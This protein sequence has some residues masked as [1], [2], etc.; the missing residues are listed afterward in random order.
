MPR[1]SKGA[2]LW[3]KPARPERGER[4][5]WLIKDRG[6][7]ISTGLGPGDRA[8]AEKRLAAYIADKYAPERRERP[9]SEIRIVDVI[10]IYLDDVVPGQARPEKAAERA[11]RLLQFFGTRTLD[12]ITGSS[13]RAYASSRHDQGRSTRGKGAERNVTSKTFALLLTI[14]PGK[15]Y[16]GARCVLSYS[17]KAKPVRDGL[18]GLNSRGSW[19]SAGGRLKRERV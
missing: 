7:R 8:E 18:R 3:L 19:G 14:M 5:C 15:D 17:K 12:E 11:E 16:T 1:H 10:R 4:A 13:C 9:L 2:Y 6:R